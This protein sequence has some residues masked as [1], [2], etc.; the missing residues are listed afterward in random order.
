MNSKLIPNEELTY[1]SGDT[2][3]QNMGKILVCFWSLW[4]IHTA[5]YLWNKDSGFG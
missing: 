3:Q 5:R 1:S 4:Q 2:F